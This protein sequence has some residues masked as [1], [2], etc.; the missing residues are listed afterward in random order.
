MDR[1]LAEK[2]AMVNEIYGKH[3][4]CDRQFTCRSK[5]EIE[6]EFFEHAEISSAKRSPPWMKSQPWRPRW[7]AS[8]LQR[9]TVR[10]C[11]WI[12]GVVKAILWVPT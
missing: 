6:K 8:F 11:E 9:R 1:E 2:I 7:P 12:G 5:G 4:L 10:P 3:R